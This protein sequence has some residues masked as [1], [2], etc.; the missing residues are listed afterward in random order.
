MGGDGFALMARAG[1]AAWHE[2]LRRW[3][4]AQR[5]AVVCGPGNNGGD[6]YVLALHALQSGREASVLRLSDHAPRS[7][8]ARRACAAFVEAG[9]QVVSF[10]GCLPDADV[11]V[12]A[13][14]GIGLARAPEADAAALI[15]ALNAAD[16][17]VLSLDAPSGVE[18]DTGAVAGSAVRAD[19]TVQFIADHAGLYTGAALDHV[20]ERMLAGLDLPAA[21]FD[22]IRPVAGCLR[23]GDLQGRFTPRLRSAH[24]GSSGYLLCIGGDHGMGGAVLLAAEAALRCGAGLV[25]VATH[26]MHVAAALARRPEVMAQA[27]DGAS[28]L[29]PLLQRADVVAIGPGL[30]QAA[31]GAALFG[32]ALA[33]GK[34]LVLDADALNLLARGGSA[35]PLAGD[36]ILTPHP[37]EAARLLGVDT[38]TVQAD[39]YAAARRLCERYRCVVVLKGAGTVVAAPGAVPQVVVAG[40]PGMASGGTGD[41]LTGV[42]AALR[43]QGRAAPDAAALGALLHAVAGDVASAAHGERG[44]VASDLFPPLRALVNG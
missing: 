20:G 29:R 9:G 3:P 42:I 30:G 33:S 4:D 40:N 28:A 13:L 15:S 12:D 19:V 18:T 17:P 24:K 27:V 2:L 1:Q 44:L 8:L 38:A 35:Q 23:R 25:G 31:W 14:F 32:V 41:V 5:V 22:D 43:A 26:P 16:V 36:A 37:G 10:D 21:I 7:P 34:P 6:G 39:R 11:A